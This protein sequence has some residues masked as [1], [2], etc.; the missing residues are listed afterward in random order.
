MGFLLRKSL[1]LARAMFPSY[2]SAARKWGTKFLQAL[3]VN[4]KFIGPPRRLCVRSLDWIDQARSNGLRIS[5]KY[6][7]LYPERTGERLPPKNLDGKVP[8]QFHA[9]YG[10][11]RFT[12]EAAYVLTVPGGRVYGEGSVITPDDQ[13]LGDISRE[14]IV[15][16]DQRQH[17]VYSNWKLPRLTFVPGTVAVL[18]VAGGDCYWHWTFD[19][20]PRIHLLRLSGEGIEGIDKF[21]TNRILYKFQSDTLKALGISIP[22]VLEGVKRHLHIRADRVIAPSVIYE[23][24]PKWA[25]DFL[26]TELMPKIVQDHPKMRKR[27]YISRADATTRRV[28]NERELVDCL[29]SFGFS[30]VTLFDKSV[31]EQATLFASAELIVAPHGSGLTNLV[32]CDPGSTVIELFSPTFINPIFWTLSETLGLEYYCFF[33]DGLLLPEPPEGIDVDRWFHSFVDSNK[34]Y[35]RDIFVNIE[36]LRCLLNSLLLASG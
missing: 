5:G 9:Y 31:S 34:T 11:M 22:M 12:E 15:G 26:R 6:E 36:P 10:G 25:C 4:S 28:L 33:G 27:L 20:L 19:S 3:P 21:I 30:T 2:Y 18:A 1:G 32:Y 14:H 17:S 35:G 16:G 8:W 23:F 7:Q 24:P 13:L 29:S